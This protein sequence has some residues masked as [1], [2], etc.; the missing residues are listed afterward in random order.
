LYS[1]D[2]KTNVWANSPV[3]RAGI[4]RPKAYNGRTRLLDGQVISAPTASKLNFCRDFNLCILQ[5]TM[6]VK[7]NTTQKPSQITKK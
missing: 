2:N 4:I 6:L 5:Q 1:K 7:T 3:G